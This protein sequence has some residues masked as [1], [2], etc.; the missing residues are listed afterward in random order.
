MKP[1]AKT[2]KFVGGALI[3][4]AAACIILPGLLGYLAGLW[5]LGLFV[6][7]ALISAW[8]VSLLVARLTVSR[9][10]KRN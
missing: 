4:G 1:S 10:G 5:R 7:L 9:Q 8:A 2:L 3:V 6:A